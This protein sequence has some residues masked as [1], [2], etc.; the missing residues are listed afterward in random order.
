MLD[1]SPINKVALDE[2]QKNSVVLDESPIPLEG[3]ES[4]QALLKRD[5]RESKKISKSPIRVLT[6]PRSA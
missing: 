5:L 3:E 1:E 2:S 6:R 4:D